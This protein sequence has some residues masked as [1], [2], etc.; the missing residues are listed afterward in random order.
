MYI[1]L[2]NAVSEKQIRKAVS[3]GAETVEEIKEKF[4]AG[5]NC[6]SCIF[7]LERVIARQKGDYNGAELGQ[8]A[9]EKSS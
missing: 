8:K 7:A 9:K 5:K 3:E 1:C 6:G 2:C 4:N